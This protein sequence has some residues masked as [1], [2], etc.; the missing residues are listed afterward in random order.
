[1]ALGLFAG[2]GVGIFEAK[3]D[4]GVF[5]SKEEPRGLLHLDINSNILAIDPA[6]ILPRP[7][8]KI[9]ESSSEWQIDLMTAS[10]CPSEKFGT[11]STS[12]SITVEK[13][14]S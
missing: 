7:N 2:M 3:S 1:M 12:L 8:F 5:M 10:F 6:K 14:A 11:H 13:M 9:I 4:D